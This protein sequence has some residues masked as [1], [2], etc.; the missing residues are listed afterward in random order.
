MALEGDSRWAG[1]ATGIHPYAVRTEAVKSSSAPM[2]T[3]TFPAML[4][5]VDEVKP[6]AVMIEKVRGDR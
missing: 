1:M 4:R 6:R 2:I 5:I 3:S